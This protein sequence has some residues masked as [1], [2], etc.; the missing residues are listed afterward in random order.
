MRIRIK[1]PGFFGIKKTD[2]GGKIDKVEKKNGIAHVFFRGVGGGGIISFSEK[3][4]ELIDDN[5]SDKKQKKT[6]KK[7]K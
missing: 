6:K 2:I 1:K 3:E 5:L 7:S 4:R